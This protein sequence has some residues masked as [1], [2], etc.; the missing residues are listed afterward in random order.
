VTPWIT[1]TGIIALSVDGTPEWL[2]I[3]LIVV[4]IVLTRAFSSTSTS[5]PQPT[6]E[7]APAA[8]NA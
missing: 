2:G 6:P 8:T 7:S 4:G 3:T 1:I 5:R